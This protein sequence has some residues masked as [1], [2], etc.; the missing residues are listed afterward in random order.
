MPTVVLVY[1]GGL[2][3][4]VCIPLMREEYGFD[5]IVTVTV[6]VGQPAEDIRLAAERAEEVGARDTRRVA[7]AAA[8]GAVIRLTPR[9]GQ[10]GRGAVT[11]T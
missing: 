1:S 5:H 6:D 4:S 8:S 3:T 2:D 7:L 9:G 11:L 10:A